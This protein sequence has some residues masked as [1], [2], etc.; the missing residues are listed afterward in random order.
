MSLILHGG[1]V[2]TSLKDTLESKAILVQDEKIVALDDLETLKKRDPQAE[3]VDVKGRTILPGLVDTHRHI[4]AYTEFIVDPALIVAGAVDGVRVAREA[5]EMGITTVRDP[6]CKHYGIFEMKRII[7]RGDIP[8][9]TIY[10]A[11][12]NPTGS[13]AP[14]SWRNVY[15]DGPWEIRKAVRELVRDGAYWIKFVVSGQSRQSGWTVT[16]WY[17]TPEEIKAGTDEAHAMGKRI[18]GHI[19][20]LDAANVV[21]DAGFDAVEHAPDIDE[22][23]AEKM[24]K[25]GVF[26]TPTMEVFSKESAQ[27][28]VKLQP[29]ERKSYEARA[30]RH[31]KSF[32]NALKAGV[33]MP[34]GTDAYRLPEKDLYVRE[35]QY[36]VKGG[37][38][39]AQVLQAAT[40]NGAG[41]IGLEDEFGTLEAGKR[42]DIIAVAGNPL[43]DLKS[44]LSVDYVLKKGSCLI[45]NLDK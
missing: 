23:L 17:L 3:L 13:A 5:I 33:R 29:S 24:A 9:P 34:V 32:G 27:W 4:I 6:G 21:V 40:R 11:G 18:S 41:V 19:E 15:V 28:E 31:L 42:A 20:G 12:P 2:F 8:G 25:K 22:K 26:Y 45:S 39:H 7:D 37:M 36:M 16:E 44:L 38:T 14:N 10:P 43:K 1:Q 35:L 30:K